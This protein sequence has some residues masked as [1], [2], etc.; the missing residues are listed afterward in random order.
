VEGSKTESDIERFTAET[1]KT[2]G[3]SETF[4]KEHLQ[5][6][7]I[8]EETKQEVRDNKI[9]KSQALATYR[10]EKKIESIKEEEKIIKLFL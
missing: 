8:K 1:A 3:K 2:I 10:K 9:N 4:V 6:Q 5:L 7:N